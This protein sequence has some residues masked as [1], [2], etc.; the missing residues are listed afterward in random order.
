[1]FEDQYRFYG[2]H[3]DMVKELK[4]VFDEKTNARIFNKY[5]GT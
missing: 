5:F 4:S 2:K 1:M 3:A